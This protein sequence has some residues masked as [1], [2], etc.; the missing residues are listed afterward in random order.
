MMFYRIKQLRSALHPVVNE[1]EY[2]WL[3]TVL[4]E[5]ERQLF[6]KQTLTEQRHALDVARDIQEQSSLIE[7]GYGKE[8]YH[9]LLSG[10]LLHD[11]GKSV[12]H[13][14]LWQR[15]FIVVFDYLPE[16]I[17]NIIRQSKS[18]FG[19]TL[20]I[21]TQHPAWG[22]RLAARAGLSPEIQRLIHNHHTPQNS[23][24]EMLH[25][26]DNRH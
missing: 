25:S 7:N 8:V 13:L 26:A 1:N 11:C 22:K 19:K 15:I 21:Y 16:R 18:V 14:L 3:N 17:K 6:L 5:R 23:M 2:S 10:A 20:V 9:N 12:I 24:E 4:S